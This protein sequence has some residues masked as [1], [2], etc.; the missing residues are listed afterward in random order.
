M[1]HFREYA[2][3]IAAGQN[4]MQVVNENTSMHSSSSC[5]SC[6]L[7]IRPGSED[8][9]DAFVEDGSSASLDLLSWASGLMCD[10]AR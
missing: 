4:N 10:S 3:R 9:P 7:V 2:D 8:S 1:I 6:S 5:A